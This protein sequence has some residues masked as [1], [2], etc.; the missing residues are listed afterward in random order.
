MFDLS[1]TTIVY[2]PGVSVYTAALPDL[3]VIVGV[4]GPNG[5]VKPISATWPTAGGSFS[6]VLPASVKGQTLRVWE[7][8]S[9]FFQPTEARP[10]GP[11][12]LSIWPHIPPGNQPQ[13]L[14]TV[15]V[16]G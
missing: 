11:I 1:W 15:G 12:D 4:S 8:S 2:A 16:Q 5:V 3:S 14:A 6:L 13:G 7:D 9:T 10:G